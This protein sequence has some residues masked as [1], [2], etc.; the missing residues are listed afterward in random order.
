VHTVPTKAL[1]LC[2]SKQRQ[3]V[4]AAD[5]SR[6]GDK[7]GSGNPGQPSVY[8]SHRTRRGGQG[9]AD[10]TSPRIEHK[11]G[12]CALSLLGVRLPLLTS[13]PIR[14]RTAMAD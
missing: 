10:R 3:A 4:G 9:V 11:R 5:L 2:D 8:D 13:K 1:G 12:G 14:L 7:N 6:Q